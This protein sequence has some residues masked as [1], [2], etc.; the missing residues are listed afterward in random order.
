MRNTPTFTESYPIQ[1]DV[2]ALPVKDLDAT[3]EWYCEHFNMTEVERRKKPNKAVI[4]ERDGVRIGFAINGDNPIHDGASILVANLLGLRKELEA[5]GLKNGSWRV[6]E[7]D[8]RKYQ[9]LLLA[10]PDGLS[11]YFHE[12]L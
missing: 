8:G 7:R 6:D 12:P 1:E 2:M 3:S 5:K 9:V 4:L 11:F 10:V